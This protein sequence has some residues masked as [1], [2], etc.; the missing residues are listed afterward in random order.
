MINTKFTGRHILSLLLIMLLCISALAACGT[1]DNSQTTAVETASEEAPAAESEALTSSASKTS[2]ESKEAADTEE[3]FSEPVQYDGI[4]LNSTLPAYEW[5]A[6]SF[7]G[8]MDPYK[9]VVYNDVTNY[10]AIVEN[11]ARVKFHRDDKVLVYQENTAD[12]LYD[13]EIVV[14]GFSQPDFVDDDEPFFSDNYYQLMNEYYD[15]KDQPDDPDE[16]YYRIDNFY[17]LSNDTLTYMDYFPAA[18]DWNPRELEI[19]LFINEGGEESEFLATLVVV[20]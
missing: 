20:D 19:D 9:V 4:D 2:S 11:G 5:V 1:K 13:K 6:S 15:G 16:V 10:K 18:S 14:S 12:T 17:R 7:P 8:V 3:D